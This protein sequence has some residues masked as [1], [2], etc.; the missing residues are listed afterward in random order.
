ME[1]EGLSPR[2]AVVFRHRHR[3]Q[4]AGDDVEFH[5]FPAN[6]IEH[7]PAASLG[8]LIL[9]DGIPVDVPAGP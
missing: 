1:R 6:F 2:R 5:L 7:P 8:A 9:R 3:F 4:E